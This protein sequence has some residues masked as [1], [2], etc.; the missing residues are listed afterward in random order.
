MKKL[1]LHPAIVLAPMVVV[2]IQI[3]V[4]GAVNMPIIPDALLYSLPARIGWVVLQAIFVYRLWTLA[5]ASDLKIKKPTPGKAVGY[6]FIPFFGLYWT[7]VMLTNLAKHL[8]RMTRQ[9]KVPVKLV[10]IGCA[11]FVAGLF[12]PL[13][14]VTPATTATRVLLD[15]TGFTGSVIMLINN[16][17]FYNAA[18]ELCESSGEK[19][20]Y[21]GA[22]VS[23]A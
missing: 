22:V 2:F 13:N 6:W 10:T 16:F 20:S 11:L 1:P 17:F 9:K 12:V 8:N 15:L 18:R 21:E 23:Y 5:Q 7:F 4:A 19:K 14:P 3:A